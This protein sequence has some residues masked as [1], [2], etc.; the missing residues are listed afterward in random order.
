LIG[1][2]GGEQ[3]KPNLQELVYKLFISS[4]VRDREKSILSLLDLEPSAQKARAY[5][6]TVNFKCTITLQQT[7]IY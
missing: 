5:L 6:Q 2:G 4:E 1:G 3:E 7:L